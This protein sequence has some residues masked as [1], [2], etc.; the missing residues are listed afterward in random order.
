MTDR[1]SYQTP[2]ARKARLFVTELADDLIVYDESANQLHTLNPTAAF[3]WR[4]CDGR[5]SVADIAAQF[6]QAYGVTD[7]T[8]IVWTA[9]DQLVQQNLVVT[10][11]ERPAWLAGLTRRE[12]MQRVAV[13]AFVMLPLVRSLAAPTPAQAQSPGT[14]LAPT[15]TGAPPPPPGPPPSSPPSPPPPVMMGMPDE[16]SDA[17]ARGVKPDQ[18]WW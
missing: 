13:G 3:I 1:L 16:G 2:M 8:D 11:M 4:L 12:L 6:G 9:L 14:T 10:E 17:S 5:T 18:V 15:T 7:A